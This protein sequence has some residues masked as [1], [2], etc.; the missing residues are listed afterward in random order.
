MDEFTSQLSQQPAKRQRRTASSAMGSADGKEVEEASDNT[1][2]HGEVDSVA[3]GPASPPSSPVKQKAMHEAGLVDGSSDILSAPYI[4]KLATVEP[5]E[6]SSVAQNEASQ[7]QSEG[8][9]G[10]KRNWQ[11]MMDHECASGSQLSL[12]VSKKEEQQQQEEEEV[13]SAPLYQVIFHQTSLSAI[14]FISIYR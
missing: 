9:Q 1:A 8:I 4:L 11:S 6:G 5:S 13:K 10:Q 2:V 12:H 3:S 7:Q 14:L